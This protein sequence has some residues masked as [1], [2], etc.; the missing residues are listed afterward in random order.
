[1]GIVYNARRIFQSKLEVNT[2]L[3]EIQETKADI[4]E[5]RVRENLA[6]NAIKALLTAMDKPLRLHRLKFAPIAKGKP[7][8]VTVP[9]MLRYA[10]YDAHPHY[11]FA[12]RYMRDHGQEVF[13]LLFTY[14]SELNKLF[15]DG[16]MPVNT[17]AINRLLAAHAEV[18]EWISVLSNL[19]IEGI[20]NPHYSKG[21]T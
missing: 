20:M 6:I 16:S 17:P 11:A 19:E 3:R 9:E 1:M 10:G 5:R 7:R 8:H 4:E 21:N 12:V 18:S 14:Q 15:P 2:R 13:T